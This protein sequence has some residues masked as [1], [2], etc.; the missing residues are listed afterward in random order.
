[1]SGTFAILLQVSRGILFPTSTNPVS[2]AQPRGRGV[3]GEVTPVGLVPQVR[4]G[5]TERRTIGHSNQGW[6]RPGGK[7]PGISI[8]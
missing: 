5:C 6:R 8:P 3:V 4:T 7:G 1:M 2:G